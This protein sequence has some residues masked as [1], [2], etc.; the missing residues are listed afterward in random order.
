MRGFDDAA[1]GVRL[2]RAGSAL[3]D[4][5]DKKRIHLSRVLGDEA[6]VVFVA[7]LPFEG[8]GAHLQHLLVRAGRRREGGITR[9]AALGVGR[10]GGLPAPV[11][12]KPRQAAAV[13]S[14]TEGAVRAWMVLS[15]R[16][17]LVLAVL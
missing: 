12:V 8:H 6:K 5:A 7:P 3:N 9:K 2:G 13:G 11:L 15:G 10:G 4:G 1:D 17:P 16:L 14:N